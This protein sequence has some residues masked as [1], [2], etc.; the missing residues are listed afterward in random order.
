MIIL[1]TV[2]NEVQYVDSALLLGSKL[3]QLY[4]QGSYALWKLWKTLDF[5]FSLEKPLKT[6]KFYIYPGKTLENKETDLCIE[7]YLN[8]LTLSK[9][10]D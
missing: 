7:A 9:Q 8:Y 6:L 3:V 2:L 1:D 4:T 10:K 5:F